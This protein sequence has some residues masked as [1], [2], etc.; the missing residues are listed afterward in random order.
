MA[1]PLDTALVDDYT[2]GVNMPLASQAGYAVRASADG[3]NYE[4]VGPQSL[5]GSGVWD[6]KAPQI[7]VSGSGARAIT[8]KN[9]YFLGQEV[10]V[11][12]ALGNASTG[13]ITVGVSEGAIN[14]V[15]SLTANGDTRTYM[16]VS[17]GVWRRAAG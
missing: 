15:T 8:L 5:A 13:T 7:L 1:T 10:T 11:V 14:G 9:G 2:A 4:F 12:D 17:A 3:T 6:G 16:Y